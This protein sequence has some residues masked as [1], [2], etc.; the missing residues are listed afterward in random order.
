DLAEVK[1][2]LDTQQRSV[3]ELRSVVEAARGKDGGRQ[4]PEAKTPTEVGDD[5][6]RARL[7]EDIRWHVANTFAA[8]RV[9]IAYSVLSAVYHKRAR[10]CGFSMREL[11]AQMENEK[12]IYPVLTYRGITLYLPKGAETELDAV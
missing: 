10:R 6:Y 4:S 7:V 1:Q 3:E 11:L 8:H 9:P 12:L 2:R 5:T